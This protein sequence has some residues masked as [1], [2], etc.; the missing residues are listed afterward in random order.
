MKRIIICLC[1]LSGNVVAQWQGVPWDTYNPP[2]WGY[3]NDQYH[4]CS[5]LWDAVTERALLVPPFTPIKFFESH[6]IPV[7]TITTI[8]VN[9]FGTFTNVSVSNISIV[10]TNQLTDFVY[11]NGTQ[12]IPVKTY[13][14]RHSNP[15]TGNDD[16]NF[17]RILNS[18]S[19]YDASRFVATNLSVN[20]N[21]ND[22]F[23]RTNI[24]GEIYGLFPPASMMTIYRD[25]GIGFAT[26]VTEDEYGIPSGDFYLTMN[27]G[28]GF[29]LG[30]SAYTGAWTFV[31]GGTLRGTPYQ[32]DFFY[33]ALTNAPVMKLT[34]TNVSPSLSVLVTG[35][36][37][38]TSSFTF[39]DNSE[40]ISLTSTNWSPLTKRWGKLTG[41]M[42]TGSANT[43]DVIEVAWTNRVDSYS[44][45][46]GAVIDATISREITYMSLD[47][48]HERQ[49][50]LDSLRW[51]DAGLIYVVGSNLTW[52]GQGAT[53][54]D[55][56]ADAQASTPVLTAGSKI[57]QQTHGRYFGGSGYTA[58]AVSSWGKLL[59]KT[60]STNLAHD[61][62]FYFGVGTNY[63]TQ[64]VFD[65][66][67]SGYSETLPS[68]TYR[69]EGDIAGSYLSYVTSAVSF[70]VSDIPPNWPSA[71][72]DDA[73]NYLGWFIDGQRAVLKYDVANGLKYK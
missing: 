17:M 15:L 67:S 3:L 57:G 10:V 36:V 65:A 52:Y 34:T 16:N 38:N 44:G 40:T 48:F 70:G 21:F 33:P 51:R 28:V 68:V 6:Q 11:T 14:W 37:Y 20:G 73:G 26:N 55:A 9:A 27:K 41:L 8:M 64:P 46:I 18:F 24:A 32:Y 58:E 13:I 39:S 50:I 63:I 72:V 56:I 60:A 25:R 71:P 35:K 45:R 42:I 62:N 7:G 53:W 2:V 49:Q 66:Q 61:C 23:S 5:Q 19:L 29:F 47:W 30:Q 22:F 43:G 59:V 54:G 1:L 31:A 12:L 4:P 69:P